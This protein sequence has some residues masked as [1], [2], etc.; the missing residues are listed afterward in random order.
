MKI[1]KTYLKYNSIEI[2]PYWNTNLKNNFSYSIFCKHISRKFT[3]DKEIT[4]FF[5]YEIIHSFISKVIYT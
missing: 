3:D 5:K 2:Q 1:Y 4:L